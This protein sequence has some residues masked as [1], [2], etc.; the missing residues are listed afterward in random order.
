MRIVLILLALGLLGLGFAF[1]AL[2]P[3]AVGIDL[4]GF[5][6]SL[7]LG[8]ALLLAALCGA[9]CAGLLLWLTMVLPQG[10]RIRRLEQGLKSA[11]SEHRK[12][13]S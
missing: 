6:L 8:F 12:S 10:R 7:R 3:A 9:L 2:N 13:H 4:F 5:Q 11:E 1:G